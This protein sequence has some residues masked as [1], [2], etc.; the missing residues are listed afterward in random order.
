MKIENIRVKMAFFAAIASAT[1]GLSIIASNYIVKGVVMDVTENT[2]CPGALVRIYADKDSVLPVVTDITDSLGRFA[3]EVDTIGRF[4][5]KTEFM[6]L[7]T[8]DIPFEITKE[9]TEIMLDTIR[10][11]G[12]SRTL[13]EFVIS[14]SKPLVE[15][16]GATLTYNMTEDPAAQSNNLLEMLRKVP[17]VTVDAE[18][19]V[20]VKGKSNFKIYLNGREN[21]MLSGDPKTI[22]KSMPASNVKKVEVITEPGARYDAEGTEG[23]L[24]IVTETKQNLDGF[25]TNLNL[26]ARKDSWGASIYA[27]TKVRN[28]TGSISISTSQ[29][30]NMELSKFTFNQVTENLQPENKWRQEW[31]GEGRSKYAYSG[32]Y[33]N[34]SWEPDTI[35]LFTLTLSLYDNKNSGI[36]S[37]YVE[38]FDAMNTKQWSFSR[39]FT[40][41]YSNMSLG[42]DGSFQHNFKNEGHNIVASY[43]YYFNKSYNENNTVSSDFENY[44]E[45]Y[46]YLRY[47]SNNHSN[48]HTF[49]ID[50]TNPLGEHNVLETGAKA[51]WSRDN[52]L[53]APWYGTT[54]EDMSVNQQESVNLAHF[55]NIQALYVSHTGKYGKWS[56]RAGVRYQHSEVGIDYFTP[57]YN[58]FTSIFNDFVPNASL[59]Y[60]LSGMQNFRL[61]Y[62]MRISRPSVSQLN[63]FVNNMTVGSVSYGNPNLN[64]VTYNNFNLSYNNYGGKIGGS[65]TLS[66]NRSD[67]QIENYSFSKDGL[68]NSTYGNIGY[69]QEF[70]VHGD[71]QLAVVNNLN[72]SLYGYLSYRMFK[73]D[74]H[75]L[76][77]KKNGWYWNYS[78]N[79]DYRMPWNI[80]IS[81]YGGQGSSWFNLQTSSQGWYFYGL[82]LS[83]N[84]LKDESL[85]LSLFGQSFLPAHRSYGY[86][87]IGE[88]V[89]SYSYYRMPQWSAGI[90]LSWRIGNLNSDVKRT[91][92]RLES[93]VPQS[94]G[95]GGGTH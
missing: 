57:G 22:L 40:Y 65:S 47:D 93:E 8:E 86:T 14:I 35:N 49:Q 2:P 78:I 44:S 3:Q 42:V 36:N 72:I 58:D 53:T 59:T 28:V 15:N 27:R 77:D 66:Y 92:S 6:G 1:I 37:Q 31:K 32:G 82:S 62:Q 74:N 69:F 46:P 17:M 20:K 7:E 34:L 43:Q 91:N 87:S 39:M 13:D 33:L 5:L 41:D 90:S 45:E 26:N 21:P 64:S 56:T 54:E 60:R 29:P 18:D 89:S 83:R 23:I 52:N 75:Y 88:N 80:N 94:Q 4:R 73:A 68:I 25:L 71:M 63:P 50:Y 19:N 61:S 85:K 81:G 16:D 70:A 67:N 84:F 95:S 76:K 51:Y 9:T 55:N 12:D 79:V 24:N 10:M 11:K 30:W 38:N 48:Y